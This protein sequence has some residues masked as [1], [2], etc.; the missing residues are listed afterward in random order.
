MVLVNIIAKTNVNT[1]AIKGASQ[2]T[3]TSNKIGTQKIAAAFITIP[4]HIAIAFACVV[5]LVENINAV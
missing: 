3:S 1:S 5:R 4:R 2:I